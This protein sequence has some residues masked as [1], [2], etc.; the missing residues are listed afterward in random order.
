ML[1]RTTS[2]L[3]LAAAL[4]L[5]SRSESAQASPAGEE[6][7]DR[8]TDE[9]VSA[10]RPLDA[11]IYYPPGAPYYPPS[12]PYYPGGYV[13]PAGPQYCSAYS[14]LS[15]SASFVN[16]CPESVGLYWIDFGC[17][18]IKYVDIPSGGQV[19]VVTYA[20]HAWRI[21]SSAYATPIGGA[22]VVNAP[23]T[24]ILCGR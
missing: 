10:R 3:F 4:G 23:G 22:F 2:T 11:P 9:D 17:N 21:R 7:N 14:S 19:Q 18:E 12:G 15:V 6:N 5:A 24:Y 8:S 13:P 1:S 16:Y 20:G